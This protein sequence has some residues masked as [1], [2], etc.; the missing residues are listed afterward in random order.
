MAFSRESHFS[1]S[2]VYNLD[3]NDLPLDRLSERAAAKRRRGAG[4]GAG[5][6]NGRSGQSDS[7]FSHAIKTPSQVVVSPAAPT[8]A[9]VTVANNTLHHQESS[10]EPPHSATGHESAGSG[11]GSIVGPSAMQHVSR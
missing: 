6:V 5:G 9:Q 4:G 2:Q 10:L 11:A 7:R 1:Y 3:L 8:V